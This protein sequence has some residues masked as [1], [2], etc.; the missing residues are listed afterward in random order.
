MRDIAVNVGAATEAEPAVACA[1][2]LAGRFGA[3]LTGLEVVPEAPS[4]AT[5]TGAAAARPRAP[6]HAA[7]A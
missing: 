6:A 7:R 2:P 5:T 4:F 3:F 1:L